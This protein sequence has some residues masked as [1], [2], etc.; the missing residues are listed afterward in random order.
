MATPHEIRERGRWSLVAGTVMTA[1]LLLAIA[2]SSAFGASV[3]SASFSGGAGTVNVG[4]T[5]YAESGGAL[6]LTV[7]TGN[8]A[9]CVDV[10]GAHTARQTSASPQTS[11]TFSFTAGAGD[12]ARQVNITVGEGSNSNACTMR[13][14]T[15]TA[16][17][18]LD[19]TGPTVTASG[20]TP[21]ANVA[22]WRN[23]NVA[24]TW[25]ASD[26]G[27]GVASGPTPSSD[28]QTGNTSGV[29]K[30]AT[31]TD[32]LGNVGNG[33][34]VIKLDKDAPQ[35]SGSRNPAANANGWNNTDVTVSFSCS[36]G[37][38]GIKSCPAP[39]IVSSDGADQSVNRTALDNADNSASTS[40]NV[41]IDTLAPSLS[42]APTTSPNAAGWYNGN[43]SVAWSCGDALSGINGSCPADSV[44]SSEGT[45]LTASASVSDK[46]GN[47]TNATSGPGVKID[48]TAPV[49]NASAP[50]AW[51][52]VDVTVDLNANDGL[53]DV[54]A[55]YY[56]INNGAVQTYSALTKPSF[57]AEGV[58]DLAYWSVD[59]AGNE[60]AHHAIPVR[61]DKTPPTIQASKSPAANANGWHKS[62]VTVSFVCG[63]GL[64][65]I[66]SCSPSA[67]VSSEGAG[68]QVSGT[69][70]DNAG[71]SATGHA[72]VS[73]DKT[74]PT[75][76]AN[77]SPAP[78]TQGWNDTAV[79]VDFSCGDVLSGIDI[80][81]AARVLGEGENQSA[82]GTAV[83]NAG[84]TASAGVDGIY[85]D[86][87]APN[88][89]GSATPAPNGNGWRNGDV[90][91]AWACS[92]ALSGIDGVCPES[93]TLT[94]EGSN[95]SASASVSDKAGNSTNATVSGIKIDRTAPVTQIDLPTPVAD[96]WFGGPVQVT[97]NP[98]DS[99]SGV[100]VTRYSIDNGPPQ[101][102]SGAFTFDQN[103]AHTIRFWSVDKAGN[104]EDSSIPGHEATINIDTVNP[105][106]SADRS[107]VANGFGWNNGPVTVGFSCSDDDSGI[108][109]SPAGCP[110][111]VVLSN[112]G[113]DQSA[114]RTAYDRV[115]NHASAG[116]SGIN[117][118]LTAPSMTGQAT[119]SPND[120]GWY[121]DDVTI[122]WTAQ[123]GLSGV[124]AS[125][126]P[127]NSSIVGEGSNLGAGPVSVVDKAGNE[128]HG[129]VSGIR[130]DRTAPSASFASPAASAS[131]ATESVTVT[132]N[133][134]DALSGVDGVS[135]NGGA[136][137][138]NA[139]GSF[140]RV[141]PL[142]CGANALTAVAT[143][144]AGHASPQ[145]SR[146]VNR[147]C[148]TASYLPPLDSS[149]A[150]GT[151]QNTV[152][153]GRVVP[154]KI[155][156]LN[157]AGLS[158]GGADIAVPTIQLG[159]LT[160][161]T[162][163]ATDVIEESYDA[164][165][166]NSNGSS[167]RWDSTAQQWI[168]NLDTKAMNLSTSY[169]YR[170][171]VRLDGNVITS[172]KWAV[173]K[174]LK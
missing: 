83:D 167:F 7:N 72:S 15:T 2:G 114:T 49:T 108:R 123:D 22:G 10:S 171:D 54:A 12:G 76:A 3:S 63:D 89:S 9:R 168:Y 96:D 111:P 24:I 1:V 82:S 145:A 79:T 42:G 17:Y 46:A 45:G 140:S 115:G 142:A 98:S 170:I 128:G 107:P 104:V 95:L 163:T 61:I 146:S 136:A 53:S 33:S 75:I 160:S 152:K 124:D 92:D 166:A 122:A 85:V 74:A 30:S 70:V 147:G 59:K 112:E 93:E 120:N 34:V 149:S 118:D 117:I 158:Q 65:G 13:T 51:N 106:I 133:A 48:K 131:V 143:D 27:S 139:D 151:V 77:R 169:C 78:N 86:T 38:S 91:V 66:A 162:A 20:I 37:V 14:A 39:A 148:H 6:S 159:R 64:S 43:V 60:E 157:A 67:V 11:W 26:A 41:N 100:D 126:L 94:G 80:C 68:Q 155:H 144:K 102:Y 56:T 32:R 164:G 161:C 97:L 71:N 109:V 174:A 55:T 116:V 99:L 103:G 57:S 113:A 5:L 87:T 62:N 29:T 23:A 36:D 28:S 81:P 129:S 141:V 105:S 84:N 119:A 16:S 88:L 150:S 21:A 154:V 137:T 35:I 25:S 156:V 134:S 130:I 47:S 135:I 40:V 127:A 101:A 125:T 73:L 31:A 69:A 50:P 90:T 153:Y 173:L 52:N 19:N 138:K 110:A 4:G 165:S 132:V 18:V 8:N 44:I 58:Y 121:R 172:S